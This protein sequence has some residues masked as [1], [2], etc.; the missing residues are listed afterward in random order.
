MFDA[1]LTDLTDALRGNAISFDWNILTG[2]EW[3]MPWMLSGGLAAGNVVEAIQISGAS[4]VDVS[5][6]VETTSGLKD[7]DLI[8]SFCLSGES[9]PHEAV[10]PHAVALKLQ[11]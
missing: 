11:L 10:R 2:R 8:R 3:P 4:A 5:S 7:P 1:K 6:G 9:T